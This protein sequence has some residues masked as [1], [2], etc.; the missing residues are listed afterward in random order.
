M[1]GR[2]VDT[3]AFSNQ[4]Q[5]GCS[6]AKHRRVKCRFAESVQPL[7]FLYNHRTIILLWFMIYEI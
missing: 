7:T 6:A 1:I 3:G 4:W 2:I 5:R